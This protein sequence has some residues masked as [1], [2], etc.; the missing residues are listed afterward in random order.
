MN[1]DRRA[2]IKVRVKKWILR[3]KGGSII[4]ACF[5]R[6]WTKIVTR[7]RGIELRGT[8]INIL[9]W[10]LLDTLLILQLWLLSDCRFCL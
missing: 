10:L 1:E 2:K 3:L 9:G 7:R 5:L 8:G 6:R 4:V